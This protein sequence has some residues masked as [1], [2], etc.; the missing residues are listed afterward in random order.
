MSCWGSQVNNA[1]PLDLNASTGQPPPCTDEQSEVDN[2]VFELLRQ[3]QN[4]LQMM[5]MPKMELM[6]FAG[7]PL[8]YWRFVRAFSNNVRETVDDS[9]KLARLTQMC[10]GKASEVIESC[11]V[12]EPNVG[13]KKARNCQMRGLAIR[14]LV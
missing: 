6:N 5:Q 8:K 14:T 3:Q 13:Y 1:A 4:V 11:V 7:D 2:P 9:V 12:I 10:V